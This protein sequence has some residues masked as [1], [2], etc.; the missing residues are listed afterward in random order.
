MKVSVISVFA[1]VALAGSL[2]VAQTPAS[3]APVSANPLTDQIRTYFDRVKGYLTKSIDMVPE[4]KWTWAPTPDVRS[5]ARMFGHIT[6]DNNGGCWQ[7]AGLEARPASLDSP[8][9]ND[10]NAQKMSRADL[11]KAYLD[12]FALCDKAFTQVND[13]NAATPAVAGGRGTRLGGLAYNWS[14]INEHYGNLVTYFRLNN[15]VP[16]SS[17]GR[18]GN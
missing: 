11:R 6:D 8:G 2:L 4:D 10:S 17:A 13:Q 5:F 1:G 7:L 14:H 12:S 3:Q 15:I 16:P 18:G 9:N